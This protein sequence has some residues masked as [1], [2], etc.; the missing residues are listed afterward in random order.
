MPESLRQLIDATVDRLSE[1]Q[2][3]VLEAASVCGSDFA[4]AAVAA[5]L[6]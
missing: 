1:D 3:R 5:A 6:D 4:A 2:Q